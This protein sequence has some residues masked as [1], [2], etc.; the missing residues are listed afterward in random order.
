MVGRCRD[1]QR[2]FN[3]PE[4]FLPCLFIKSCSN[5][6]HIVPLFLVCGLSRYI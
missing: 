4:E 5:V 6:L 1:R 2:K 3:G